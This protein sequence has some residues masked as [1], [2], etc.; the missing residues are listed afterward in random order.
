MNDNVIPAKSRVKLEE[1]LILSYPM[2]Q[3]ASLKEKEVRQMGQEKTFHPP[4]KT[5]VSAH[6]PAKNRRMPPDKFI[7]EPGF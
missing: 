6:Q 7:G 3:P 1:L 2:A 5:E 4:A